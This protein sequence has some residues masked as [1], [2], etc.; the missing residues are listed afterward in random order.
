MGAEIPDDGRLVPGKQVLVQE[1]LGSIEVRQ[2][3]IEQSRAL[4]HRSFDGCPFL[5]IDYERH[6]IE[7]PWTVGA[8]RILIDIISNAIFV[9]QA[10]SFLP[11]VGEAV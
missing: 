3:G 6:R 5:L 2:E 9:K 1:A 11:S 4:S 8:A 7:W 10:A